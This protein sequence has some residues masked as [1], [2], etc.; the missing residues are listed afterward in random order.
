MSRVGLVLG[1]GGVTG[2]AFHFGTLFSLRMATG[3][4]P[5]DA[6]V[7]VGTS[8]GAVVAALVRSRRL[9]L[10][11]L[12][13]DVHGSS[14]LAR[15]LAER[16]YRRSRM[17]G[18]GRWMRHGLLPGLRHP[19]IRL[20]VGSPAPYTTDGIAD[21]LRSALGES[22]TSWP[23]RPTTI[24]AYEIE[25][26]TRVA[27]GT[28]GSPD[29]DLV[30]AVAA[31]SAVPMVFDPVTIEGRRYV[32]GG[33]ISGTS[34]DLVLGSPEPLD[35]V[36]VVAPMAATDTRP[37]A[38]FYEGIID[39]LGSQALDA[40]LDLVAAE[41]PDAEML[42]LRPD[43]SILSETRPNPLSTAAALPAFLRTLRVMR[44][45]LAS[46][47]VWPVLERHLSPVSRRLHW[48]RL[49]P[50]RAARP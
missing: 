12:V 16:I 48:G 43:G 34:A 9:N 11:A 18:V 15:A 26:R 2:A 37:E 32:D 47:A 21:W 35:L 41:W 14:E 31:S 6:D 23:D 28:E 46:E 42:V 8:S 13:G 10:E 50:F 44:S 5:A 3:W 39:R 38:R 4:E 19:G 27:F 22:A 40:E 49:L 7:V 20:A 33:I 29:T 45:T 36:I 24:V 1:G 25:S 30:T 17:H